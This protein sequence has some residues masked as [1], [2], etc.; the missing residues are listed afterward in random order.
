MTASR[1]SVVLFTSARTWRGSS[2]S[3]AAIAE[4]LRDA[5]HRVRMLAGDEA[6]TLGFSRLGL[7]ASRVPIG[8]TGF[9]EA[10]ALAR[11]LAAE[12]ADAILVD[13]PRDLRLSALASLAHPLAIVNCYNLSRTRPPLDL[14]SH[15]A[16]RRVGLTI[17]VSQTSAARVLA[18]AGYIR[19]RPH[20]VIHHAVDGA[21][22]RPDPEAAARFRAANGLDGRPFVLAVGSLTLDKRYDFL[23]DVWSRLG[24]TAPPLL[25]CGEGV[26]GQR[27]RA[28]ARELALDV[29][30]LGHLEPDVLPQAFAAATCFV[31]AGAVETFGLSVLE[32]MASGAAVL[33]AGAGAVPEVLGNTGVLA[34]ADDPAGFAAELRALLA[35]S[36]R[37]QALGCAARNRAMDQ[38]SPAR[39]RASYVEAIEAVAAAC[40]SRS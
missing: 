11:A 24:V 28:R 2:V 31:H 38:F 37:R 10:R 30:F 19:R 34:S 26:H 8:N 36:P 32:A 25:V 35:D 12:Q 22:F 40:A 20:R 33:A 9:K 15:L 7:P 16:Y 5:G 6:V 17:F 18:L 21:R 27:L 3:F 1:R 13:R 29:R 23:L 4:G 14:L 39:M